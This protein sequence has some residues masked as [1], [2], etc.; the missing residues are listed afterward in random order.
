[1]R[2][3]QQR[4]AITLPRGI[5]RVPTKRGRGEYLY[6]QAGRGTKVEGPRIPLPPDVH[7]PEFWIELRKAQGEPAGPG[8]TTINAVLDLYL[9]SPQFLGLAHS[10]QLQFKLKITQFRNAVGI[11]PAAALRP[12]HVR[13]LLD[14]LAHIPGSANTLLG[15]LRIFSKWGLER[16]HFDHSITE[17]VK[18]YKS[19]TG[20]VPWT[21]EQCVVAEKKLVGMMRRAYFLARYSG[22]RGSDV[23]RLGETFVDE[24]GFR[25]S[26]KKTGKRIGDIWI[27]IEPPLAAEM[28]TWERRPGPF[29]YTETG[30]T[31]TKK[32]LEDRWRNAIDAVPELAGVTFHGLRG[33]RV[34]ELRVRGHNTLEI[35]AQVGM[36]PPMIERYCRFADKKALGKAAVLNLA[37]ARNRKGGL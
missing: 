25:L 8:V 30:K 14:T 23:I 21:A 19:D 26:P 7:S 11:H 29:L 27:P 1:M 18:P 31:F 28:G 15:F 10:T 34:V 4:A 6:Y 33:T 17:G 3:K 20:H 24:G 35:S 16:G 22:Q 9:I 2:R 32:Y 13:E 12:K 36:S 5:H 37:A